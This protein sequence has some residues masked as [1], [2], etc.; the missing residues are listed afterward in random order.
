VSAYDTAARRGNAEKSS[1]RIIWKRIRTD[2]GGQRRE[3]SL[4]SVA[5]YDCMEVSTSSTDSRC[6]P[7]IADRQRSRSIS[8]CR[9]TENSTVGRCTSLEM[10][11]S[12]SKHTFIIRCCLG[13]LYFKY[14]LFVND[15]KG[16]GYNC[17]YESFRTDGQWLW[18]HAIAFPRWQHSAVG[19]EA[20][21]S[22]LF[23]F[24]FIYICV[25]C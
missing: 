4:T 21:F 8:V 14:L 9:S 10:H 17:R 18:Y 5:A 19:R 25:C 2:R 6:S 12:F 24:R 11:L 23:Y 22:L 13:G 20:R 16:N 1:D 15:I 7:P 3:Q